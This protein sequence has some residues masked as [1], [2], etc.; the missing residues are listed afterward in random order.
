MSQNFSSKF[1]PVLYF[2]I[3]MLFFFA[4]WVPGKRR[5]F[6][7]FFLLIF[8][9]VWLV[10]YYFFLNERWDCDDVHGQAAT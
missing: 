4:C 5:N 7:N 1:V 6:L 3:P 10:V 2:V 9:G 8:Q